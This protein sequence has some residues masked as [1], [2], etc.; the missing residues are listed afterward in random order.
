LGWLIAAVLI[1]YLANYI[2]ENWNEIAGQQWKIRWSALLISGLFLLGAY[3]V[4]SLGWRAII[5]GF[6][7][8][9]TRPAA[10]RV[11]YLSNLGRYIPG[12]IWQVFGMVGLAKELGVPVRVSLAS[13]ALAQLYMIPIGF[14]VIL[15]TLRNLETIEALKSVGLVLYL[16]AGI[17][18]LVFLILL[19][20]PGGFNW[21]LNLILRLFRREMVEYN[22]RVRNR[23]ITFI[24][25]MH[26]WIFFGL[27]FYFFLH[28]LIETD[29]AASHSIGIYT[30][31]YTLG[32]LAFISP[33]GLGVREAVMS[34]ILSPILGAPVAASIAL[35]NRVW[36]TI[37][38][39]VISLLAL[40]TYRI[41]GKSGRTIIN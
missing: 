5:A 19:F 24:L 23:T 20:K 6:G 31:S 40:L 13:F 8:K 41:K 25:Y 21:G 17:I 32:Y 11:A 26:T 2:Q 29:L 35:A 3:I 39:V 34:A 4:A 7:Y 10:F 14:M 1:F 27:G 36:I 28:A 15:I 18:F 22:P 9:V 33:G 30:A 12:K 16:A 37:A 38:E